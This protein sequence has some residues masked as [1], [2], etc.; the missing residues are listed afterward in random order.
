MRDD[1]ATKKVKKGKKRCYDDDEV[2]GV[3][4]EGIFS[5]CES[6]VAGSDS[7]Y[8]TALASS[9][10]L[11]LDSDYAPDVDIVD[12]D[13]GDDITDFSYD[14][15]DPCIDVDVVFPDVDQCKSAVTHHAI[16]HGYA[17]TTVKKSKSRFRAKCKQAESGCKWIFFA[18]TSKKYS[19]CKVIL[20]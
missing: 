1:E 18:S 17:Y 6:L 19:G 16:L 5:D 12:T 14:V 7:S 3:D 13:E 4:E 15:D 8:D 20:I 11:E 9:S 2:V 10:N